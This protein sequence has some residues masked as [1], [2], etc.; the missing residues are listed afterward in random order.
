MRQQASPHPGRGQRRA[1]NYRVRFG[2][3][4]TGAPETRFWAPAIPAGRQISLRISSEKDP[5]FQ[6]FPLRGQTVACGAKR[7]ETFYTKGARAVSCFLLI[8]G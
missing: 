5:T 1:K 4:Q 6:K 8:F 2:V 3:L 7:D